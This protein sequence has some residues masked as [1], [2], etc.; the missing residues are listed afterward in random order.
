MV[1]YRTAVGAPLLSGLKAFYR[2]ALWSNRAKTG[3][4]QGGLTLGDAY[5]YIAQGKANKGQFTPF[6]QA[7]AEQGGYP[8]PHID[9]AGPFSSGRAT[10]SSGVYTPPLWRKRGCATG[11]LPCQWPH[12]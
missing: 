9:R 6:G 11:N 10:T 7:M 3:E 1:G 8:S 5:G 2:K 4:Y 12:N